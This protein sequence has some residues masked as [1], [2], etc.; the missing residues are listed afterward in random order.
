MLGCTCLACF[1]PR[2]AL[3]RMLQSIFS[4]SMWISW[5]SCLIGKGQ[6]AKFFIG[7]FASILR[8]HGLLQGQNDTTQKNGI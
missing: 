7:R 8:S 2:Q 1:L 6:V 5:S 4:N 3:L